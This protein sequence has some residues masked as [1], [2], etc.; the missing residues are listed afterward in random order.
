MLVLSRLMNERIEVMDEETGELIGSL[1]IVEVRGPKVRLGFDFK[2]RYSLTR[3][4]AK[5]KKPKY[6]RKDG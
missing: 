4:N 3:D 1:V 2:R 5:G 6:K